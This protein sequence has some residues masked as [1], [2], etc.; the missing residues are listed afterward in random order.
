MSFMQLMAQAERNTKSVDAIEQRVKAERQK[1]EREE[2]VRREKQRKALLEA[3]KALAKQP[4][5]PPQKTSSSS[6]S[7]SAANSKPNSTS[8]PAARIPAKPPRPQSASEQRP[9]SVKAPKKQELT[10]AETARKKTFN[11]NQLMA[12]AEKVSLTDPVSIADSKPSSSTAFKNHKTQPPPAA[13]MSKGKHNHPNL[14]LI[15]LGSASKRNEKSAMQILE[16]R[17]EADVGSKKV[18]VNGHSKLVERR[19]HGTTD[20][21]KTAPATGKDAMR[22]SAVAS[23]N[24]DNRSVMKNGKEVDP[25]RIPVSKEIDPRRI[26][27]SNEVDPRKIPAPTASSKSGSAST[28]DRVS[29]SNSKPSASSKSSAAS[30][31]SLSNS[32]SKEMKRKLGETS[33]SNL[34]NGSEPLRKKQMKSGSDKERDRDARGPV[35]PLQKDYGG[36]KSED[37]WS[38]LGVKRRVYYESDDDDDMEVGFNSVRAEESRSARLARLEDAEEER[39]EQE[40]LRKKGKL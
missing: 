6:A 5:Q 34:A 30:S 21:R 17:H 18:S 3:E 37:I 14:E 20:L 27:I 1:A 28:K 8:S 13:P 29:I 25:R 26:P 4:P 33:G 36:V 7:H 11:F 9:Q 16:A 10:S 12:K 23:N 38:I 19:D 39:R 40:R 35:R 24:G 2:S 31:P 32:S 15:P 22:V